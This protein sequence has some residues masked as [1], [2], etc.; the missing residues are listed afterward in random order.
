MK[1]TLTSAVASALAATSL[2]TT[3]CLCP[4]QG[5]LFTDSFQ[6]GQGDWTFTGGAW[7]EQ[8]VAGNFAPLD[9]NKALNSPAISGGGASGGYRT[10][11][12]APGMAYSWSGNI[13]HSSMGL[14]DNVYGYAIIQF[15]GATGDTPI[16]SVETDPMRPVSGD[17]DSFSVSG[18]APDDTA[19]VRFL[20]QTITPEQDAYGSLYY[21]LVQAEIT[22]VPEPTAL[23]AIPVLV[24]AAAASHLR[25]FRKA[26]Q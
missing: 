9:G 14:A 12:S 5:L 22:G 1:R 4:A 21:D 7:I 26:R 10:F 15:L 2:L 25:S 24:F 23:W 17:W 6:G 20:L 16:S 11:E 8:S 18:T 13:H 3:I 19:R